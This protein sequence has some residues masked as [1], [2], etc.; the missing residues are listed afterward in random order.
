MIPV[1]KRNENKILKT[2]I[3]YNFKSRAASSSEGA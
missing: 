2:I 3:L 1:Q